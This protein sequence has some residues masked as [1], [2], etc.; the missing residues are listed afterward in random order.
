[1]AR[2]YRGRAGATAQAFV[3]DHLSQVPGGRFYR[4]GDLVRWLPRGEMQF[5]GRRD[6]Q[7]KIRGYR[8]EPAEIEVMLAA[9]PKVTEAAVALHRDKGEEQLVA[10]VA[11]SLE[12][13]IEALRAWLR[14]QFPEYM[15]P[16]IFF[17]VAA[18][19]RTA[20]G[21]V[22]RG[23]LPAPRGGSAA[24]GSAWQPPRNDTE[25]AMA[26]I[27]GDLLRVEHVGA[28][29][30]FFDLGGHSLLATQLVARVRETFE[31]DLPLR[32]VF[33]SPTVAKLAAEVVSLILDE[34]EELSDE[35]LEAL[36]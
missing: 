8:V 13:D 24:R 18:L 16:S 35:E 9:H 1:V 26:A 4:T 21:K 11:G 29:D 20:G 10:Y 22:D 14:Q 36:N 7:V 28:F 27:F 6:T 19:P 5:L 3:P 32:Q 17:P 25:E 23:A 15:V 12:G 34:L 31:V 30:H 33:E 2:G